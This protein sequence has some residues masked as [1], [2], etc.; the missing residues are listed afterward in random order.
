MVESDGMVDA[1]SSH[2]DFPVLCTCLHL[3][4]KTMA[5]FFAW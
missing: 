2:Q 3:L 4:L 1:E 5:T